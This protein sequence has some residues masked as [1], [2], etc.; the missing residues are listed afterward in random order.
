MRSGS[1]LF[2]GVLMRERPLFA[3]WVV[4][5]QSA[6]AHH[7][8]TPSLAE[9]CMQVDVSCEVPACW[10]GFSSLWGWATWV[11][12]TLDGLRLCF[13]HTTEILF[14]SPE[15]RFC[16][17]V[18]WLSARGQRREYFDV[19]YLWM[20]S[21]ECH[22]FVSPEANEGLPTVKSRPGEWSENI[23]AFEI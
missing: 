10:D 20:N 5:A 3:C 22:I 13:G 19:I 2:L 12:G 6:K 16:L 23:E 11:K 14:M 1:R 8:G 4:G 21:R 15:S 18:E 17:S 7:T 9:M